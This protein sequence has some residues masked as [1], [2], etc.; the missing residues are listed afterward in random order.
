MSEIQ[1]PLP[2]S[3]PQKLRR[4]LHELSLKK[5]PSACQSTYLSFCFKNLKRI[6]RNCPSNPAE[7]QT[8]EHTKNLRNLHELQPKAK[9]KQDKNKFPDEN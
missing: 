4:Q 5:K 6:L 7:T 9:R 8:H 2:Q 1:E 3:E